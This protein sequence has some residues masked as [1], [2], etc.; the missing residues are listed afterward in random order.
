MEVVPREMRCFYFSQGPK[1]PMKLPWYVLPNPA[2][3]PEGQ[4]KV[5]LDDTLP[6]AFTRH[7]FCDL[8][9]HPFSVMGPRP[10][11]SCLH[12][13]SYGTRQVSKRLA[14]SPVLAQRTFSS[15]LRTQRHSLAQSQRSPSHSTWLPTNTVLGSLCP[16]V[17]ETG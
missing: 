13:E 5:E 10:P 1:S 7:T 12:G 17:A 6:T 14:E 16:V 15:F 3:C 2:H 11:T 4:G 8:V 9:T